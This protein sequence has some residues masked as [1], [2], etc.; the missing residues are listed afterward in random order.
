LLD[1]PA[2]RRGALR[3]AAI[4][5]CIAWSTKLLGCDRSTTTS[6]FV[7]TD[8][9]GL[10]D[11]DERTLHGTSP[12]LVDTDG[13]G[14]SDYDE[15]VLH[16]FD[17]TNAPLRFNPR[18]ADVPAMEVFIRD[19]PLVSL[20]LTTTE[21]ESWT[22]ETAQSFETAI[23]F[24][25]SVTET[26][27]FSQT[28]G[29]TDTINEE[30]TIEFGLDPLVFENT[31][32]EEEN[33]P[34]G[35]P[36]EIEELPNNAPA[37]LLLTTG[38][39]ST[40]NR[41]ET[42][43]VT[44][45]FTAEQARE[46]RR[47]LTIAQAFTQSHNISASGGILEVLVEIYNRG[48][49]PFRVSNMVLSASFVRGDDVEIPVGNL[50]IN[51]LFNNFIPYSLAPGGQQG[52]VNF[53]RDFLT[54]EQVAALLEDVQG[55]KVRVGVYELTDAT[56]KPY[57]FDVPAMTSRTASLDIDYGAR[58]PPERFLVATNID[59]ARLGITSGRSFDDVLRIPFEADPERGLV[60]LRDVGT[61]GGGRWNVEL[62][63]DDGADV[64]TTPFEPPYDFP[65]ILLR[66]GDVLRLAWVEEE[67]SPER[68]K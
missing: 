63:H 12:L 49:L 13:D 64:V 54:L 16:G 23:I 14:I 47:A 55:L 4:I 48:S 68:R 61:D 46:L 31:E 60:S 36:A 28:F 10:S 3:S 35:N 45:S 30:V 9:D 26:N 5:G 67:S 57:V 20:Q 51:T 25:A 33:N 19:P 22:W 43:G 18:V 7:D 53:S 42:S 24:S 15:I 1:R 11:V 40:I 58:R 29:L 6:A 44:L 52:P 50:D 65:E 21:G 17:P 27:S 8:G 34:N 39:S 59:P 66:S 2:M 41:S 62:V 38:I 56:G 32:A 37:S